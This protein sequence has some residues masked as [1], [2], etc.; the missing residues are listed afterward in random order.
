MRRR[1]VVRAEAVRVELARLRRG[2]PSRWR[3]PTRAL[4]DDRTPAPLRALCA[5]QAQTRACRAEREP[6]RDAQHPARS[7][8]SR[9]ASSSALAS[10]P[11]DLRPPRRDACTSCGARRSHGAHRRPVARS[12]DSSS[13]VSRR[14]PCSITVEASIVRSS[15]QEIGELQ[16]RLR[17]CTRGA[18][19]RRAERIATIAS[20]L[21][22]RGGCRAFS[23]RRFRLSSPCAR[24]HARSAS[25]DARSASPI[26][27]PRNAHAAPLR[28]LDAR[29]LANRA[30]PTPRA[31]RSHVSGRPPA[32]PAARARQRSVRRRIS[33]FS[34]RSSAVFGP[35][36]LRA[37]RA[38]PTAHHCSERSSAWRFTA[39]CASA[40]SQS[41]SCS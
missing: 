16:A 33:A 29:A 37:T 19:P 30:P 32:P 13:G 1:C 40:R 5:T 26:S 35:R 4:R 31:D 12:A 17:R 3:S 34:A 25:S 9:F 14:M 27:A 28:T 21:S 24:L 6:Y 10:S 38:A 22:R 15:Q 2:R 23:A 41:P 7:I 18:A 36:D 8:S 39:A 20:R 11:R